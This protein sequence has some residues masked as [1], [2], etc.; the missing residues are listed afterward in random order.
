VS[1]AMAVGLPITASFLVA[2]LVDSKLEV[3]SV[4]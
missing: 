3:W 2:C 1:D 4:Q